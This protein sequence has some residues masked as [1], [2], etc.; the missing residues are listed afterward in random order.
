MPKLSFINSLLR[1][2]KRSI[3]SDILKAGSALSPSEG[4]EVILTYTSA[5]DKMHVCVTKDD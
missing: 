2:G 4:D 3:P 5:V 1:R